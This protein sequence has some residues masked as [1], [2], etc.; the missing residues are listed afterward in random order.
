MLS[1]LRRT[2]L[3]AVLMHFMPR[4]QLIQRRLLVVLMYVRAVRRHED[5]QIAPNQL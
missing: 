5:P 1:L 3:D 2:K 4:M